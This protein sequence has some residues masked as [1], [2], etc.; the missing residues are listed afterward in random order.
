MHARLERRDVASTD[1][2]L[3]V[4]LVNFRTADMTI[5]SISSILMHEIA[6]IENIIVVDN[7]SA[8]GSI[9]RISA[10]YPR[11]RVVASSIN[12]GFGAGVNLGLRRLRQR[13]VLVLNPDTYFER[14]YVFWVIGLMMA[15][16]D[17]GI[18][19]LDL[20]N[21]DGSRQYSARRF[22]SLLDVAARR[23]PKIGNALQGRMAKHLME[24]A[25]RSG[26]PFDAEWVMGTGFVA[27][28]QV[29]ATLG[30]FDERY[31][32]YMEDVDLCARVWKAGFRVV[33]IPGARL[34]HDHRRSSAA[35]PLSRAGLRHLTSLVKFASRFPVPVFTQ[36][37][38]DRIRRSNRWA[39]RSLF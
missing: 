2:L 10:A 15:N 32:L 14:N 23:V 7:N 17:I 19:G 37:G 38:I 4:V 18:A 24:D 34:V 25:W 36:P 39:V 26:R 31:F 5:R 16:P 35:S 22:Y 12:G 33:G 29:I 3:G 13:Y 6:N 11:L 8:D 9:D 21:K 27:N 28:R 20:V 30:G 1:Q